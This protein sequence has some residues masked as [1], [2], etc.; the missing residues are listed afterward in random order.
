MLPLRQ[1]CLL[2]ENPELHAAG[3]FRARRL[4]IQLFLQKNKP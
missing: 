2:P 3:W 1:V 4:E